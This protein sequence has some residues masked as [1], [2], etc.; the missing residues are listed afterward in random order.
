MAKTGTEAIGNVF[1]PDIDKKAL[2]KQL[3]ELQDF[4]KS[5]LVGPTQENPLGQDYG[6]AFKVKGGTKDVLLLP[7][8]QKLAVIWGITGIP[9]ITHR[10]ENW[11]AQ[12]EGFWAPLLDYEATT[13]FHYR[14]DER[15][16]AVGIGAANSYESKWLYRTNWVHGQKTKVVS[17]EIAGQKNTILKIC[18]KRAYVPGVLYETALSGLFTQDIEAGNEQGWSDPPAEFQQYQDHQ[19]DLNGIINTP[20]HFIMPG[21]QLYTI[22]APMP[23]QNLQFAPGTVAGGP[24]NVNVVNPAPQAVQEPPKSTAADAISSTE[25]NPSNTS[26]NTALTDPGLS[27]QT[28]SPSEPKKPAA[29]RGKKVEATVSPIEQQTVVQQP[30]PTAEPTVV[31]AP[32]SDGQRPGKEHLGLICDKAIAAGYSRDEGN[33][34]AVELLASFGVDT[35]S[36]TNILETWN[37]GHVNGVMAWFEMNKKA[38]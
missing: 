23:D 36:L 12:L 15:K 33:K 22:P 37:G 38:A 31:Q 5:I 16:A 1:I 6:P 21:Q 14:V 19:R 29:P 32:S 35:S 9:E 4:I 11:Q 24:D 18:C 17:D 8:A 26:T 3:A 13:R 34:K 30:M 7:G 27:V 25:S 28:A 10:Y 2:T 20:Q